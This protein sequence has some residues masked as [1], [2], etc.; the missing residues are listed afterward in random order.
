MDSKELTWQ[1]ADEELSGAGLDSITFIRMI[2][3]L[4]DAFACRIPD[5]KLQLGEMNTLNKIAEVLC[6]VMDRKEETK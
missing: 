5:E 6:M 2:V 1:E 3:A 4:E